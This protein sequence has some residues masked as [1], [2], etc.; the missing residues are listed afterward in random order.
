[1]PSMFP[2]YTTG[3]GKAD[4]LLDSTCFSTADF[5]N[6]SESEADS[7][8]Y[9]PHSHLFTFFP[10]MAEIK[11]ADTQCRPPPGYA[12]NNVLDKAGHE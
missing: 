3:A 7:Y 11:A 12:C 2:F 4:A 10:T 6:F 1:M 8:N 5:D 9:D